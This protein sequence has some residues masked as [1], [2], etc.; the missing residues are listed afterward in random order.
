M[1]D[2]HKKQQQKKY[3]TNMKTYKMIHIVCEH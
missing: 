1:V 3:H 2:Q